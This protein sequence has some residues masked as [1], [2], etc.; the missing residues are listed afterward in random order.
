[1]FFKKLKENIRV[2][3]Y[4]DK[5]S[6]NNYDGQASIILHNLF[7]TGT[8]LPFTPFALNPNTILHL[9][10]DINLNNR[11]SII[12]FGAGLSTIILAR[13]IKINNLECKILS[14][15]DNGSWTDFIEKQL[16]KYQCNDIVNILVAPITKKINNHLWYDET[17]IDEFILN[18]KFDVVIVDGPSAKY[19]EL[20][21]ENALYN[22]YKNLD[23]DFFIVLDDIRRKGESKIYENWFQFLE[24]QNT[25]FK[26]HI[27]LGR[28]YGYFIGGESF[29]TNPLTH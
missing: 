18:K 19:H 24:K 6:R 3:F 15:D 29:S 8:V 13:Y 11:K 25:S 7:P 17:V 21:R 16:R 28:V 12:E 1:M 14:V 27:S 2:K 20:V 10:N 23:H 4:F 22:I 26:S 5:L 9:I